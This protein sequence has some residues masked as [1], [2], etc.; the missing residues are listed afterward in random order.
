MQTM[1]SDWTG[2]AADIVS[3]FADKDVAELIFSYEGKEY[4]CQFG[5][6]GVP[7]YGNDKQH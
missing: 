5:Q 7:W 6:K 3:L 2:M 1:I 4:L